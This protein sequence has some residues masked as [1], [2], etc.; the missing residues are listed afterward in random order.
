V[1]P[2]CAAGLADAAGLVDADGW[3]GASDD[4]VTGRPGELVVPSS[5]GLT[6]VVPDGAR[7]STAPPATVATAARAATISQRRT[8]RSYASRMRAG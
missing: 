8:R 7:G 6:D 1:V 3:A 2:G 5:I 4:G